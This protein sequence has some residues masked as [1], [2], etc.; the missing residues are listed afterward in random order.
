[1]IFKIEKEEYVNRTFRISKKLLEQMEAVC[2]SKNV[3]LNKLMVMCVE[4]ALTNLDKE[5]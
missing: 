5:K 2:D 1:M 4:F 3:S